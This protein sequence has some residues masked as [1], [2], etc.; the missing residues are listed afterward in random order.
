MSITSFTLKNHNILFVVFCC[1]NWSVGMKKTHKYSATDQMAYHDGA[2][3]IRDMC[4]VCTLHMHAL[5]IAIAQ[6]VHIKCMQFTGDRWAFRCKFVG[7]VCVLSTGRLYLSAMRCHSPVDMAA[8]I[9]VHH[10]VVCVCICD[11]DTHTQHTYIIYLC[12]L[13]THMS[14]MRTQTRSLRTPQSNRY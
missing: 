8:H 7:H 9:C 6:N 13:L 3:C 5:Q 1:S 10:I 2:R 11:T 4:N 14:A 12:S